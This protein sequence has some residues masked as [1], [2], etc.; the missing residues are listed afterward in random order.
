MNKIY[1]IFT[2]PLFLVGCQDR[3]T[4]HPTNTCIEKSN[5][6]IESFKGIQYEKYDC[7]KYKLT[8]TEPLE[9]WADA[10]GRVK[11]RLFKVK[12]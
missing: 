8:C 4:Y 12:E 10:S 2:L 11:C 1:L 7:Q 5:F 9:L 6:R 3:E